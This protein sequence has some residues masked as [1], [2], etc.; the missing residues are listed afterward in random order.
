MPTHFHTPAQALARLQEGHLRFQ[1]GQRTQGEAVDAALL[2]RIGNRPQRPLATVL[3]CSDSRIPI[4]SLFDCLPGEIFMIRVAGNVVTSEVLAS[5]EFATLKLGSPLCLVLGHT[6][7]GAVEAAALGASADDGLSPSLVRLLGKVRPALRR[8]RRAAGWDATD[9][10]SLRSASWENARLSA[11][12]VLRK[13]PLLRGRSAEGAFAI[14]G[15]LCALETGR[16]DFGVVAD[17]IAPRGAPLFADAATA[18][19]AGGPHA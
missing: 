8:L 7:C 1:N 11:R 9:P 3:S 2:A 10:A 6:G 14:H 15:A 5:I 18:P 17:A 4:E 12:T 13:S 19:L 16:I